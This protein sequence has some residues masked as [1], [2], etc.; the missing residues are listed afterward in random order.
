LTRLQS[1]WLGLCF[2][3]GIAA[4]A[5]IS[6][7]LKSS[8]DYYPIDLNEPTEPIAPYLIFD[9]NGKNR[10]TKKLRFQWR[11]LASS[12][13]ESR[14]S[15][16]KAYGDVPEAFLEH[17]VTGST[18]LRLG[19]NTVNWGVTDVSSP[20][21][22]INPGA[23]FHPMRIFKRGSPMVELDF[24]KEVFGVHAI[25][26][27][28][29]RRSSLPSE[30]SR[31]LPRE[32]LVNVDSSFG[33]IDIPK[34]LEYDI[35][36]DE[37]LETGSKRNNLTTNALD[38]NAGLRLSSH[39]GSLDLF[40]M[41]FEGAAPQ[42]K[43]RPSIT[44]DTSTSPNPTALTPIGLRP[45]YYR[46]RT[47]GVGLVYA[48]EKVILRGE[49]AYQHTINTDPLLQPW[50]WSS[51]VALET[52]LSLGSTSL[53]LLTQFYY[54]ENPQSPDNL[55]SSS[56]RLFD[57]TGVLGARWAW[58][59]SLTLNG[60]IL[61]EANTTGVFAQLGFENK[62]SDALRWGL[63]WRDFSSPKEGLIKTYDSNDHANLDL[64]Y[65]F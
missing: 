32:F 19:L 45:M 44:I 37:V 24:D 53:I 27:P 20:S 12:N 50:M 43:V 15:P 28:R 42:P 8:T 5:S 6:G 31:W 21:D 23:F 3:F 41:H 55:I 30:D 14:Y 51:V 33:R 29:Q 35:D 16:E 18:R 7:T 52:N 38:H 34:Q 9:A 59:E 63:S 64:T 65:Y 62:I 57:R 39:L 10:F 40:A 49:S 25:Y 56:Y 1:A 13:L 48:F 22:V 61:F 17:K 46:V 36:G 26:I 4:H 60:S 54:T 58:S 2:C 47:S 11:L